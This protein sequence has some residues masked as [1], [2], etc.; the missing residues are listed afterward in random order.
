MVT[1]PSDW[2][3]RNAD[4]ICDISTGSGD[5]KDA[6]PNGLFPFFVRS[7]K[8]ERINDFEFEGEAVLTAGD[9]VGTGKVF[10]YVDGKF[11][12]HQRVYVLNN[13]QNFD[14]RF[15]YYYFSSAFL[16]EV[17]KYTAKS[18]VDSVRRPMIANMRLP[19]PSLPEQRAIAEVLSGFDEHLANL[20]ELITKKWAIR[21]G[22][23]EDLITGRT[24][25]DGFKSSWVTEEVG[26]LLTILHG[27][28]QHEVENRLGLY[29]I[30]GTGGIIGR[31]DAYLCDWPCVTIGR[32][33][34][35]D[36]PM[37]MDEPFWPIDTL[38]YSRSAPN[39]DPKFQ[40]Y[41]FSTIDWYLYTESSGRPSLGKDVI[42]KIEVVVPPTRVE[43]RA[44]AEVLSG[45]DEEIRLLVE[46][47]AKVECLK[48]GA[49]K[50]LLTG[51]VRLPVD[52]EAA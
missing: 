36:R 18:S 45:M 47:R 8:V 48:L 32:K 16:G 24:R 46:E 25:L 5:T 41:L 21:D 2:E 40:Y 15:F 27:K 3:F 51:R 11:K 30:F 38:Y 22:V 19:R 34:T 6:V 12:A 50:D 49:M 4:E 7:K 17:E 37:Y 44:I 43:Q 35:I 29:P 1:Y 14:S 33:G 31:A 9:G 26:N 28:S 23:L 52:E 42:E 39:S 13:F 10:H 20:D